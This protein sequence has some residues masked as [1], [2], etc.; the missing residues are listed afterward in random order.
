M[1]AMLAVSCGSLEPTASV[2][3]DVYFMPSE[4]P[5]AATASTDAGTEGTDVG[6]GQPKSQPEGYDYYDPATAE[7]YSQRNYYDMAYNDPYYYNYGRFGFG[8]SM[9][10]MS[11]WNGP[12]W[13]GGMGMGYGYPMGSGWSMS[14]GYGYGSG[15]YD[16]WYGGWGNPYWNRPYGYSPWG[17]NDPYMGGYGWGNY[18]GPYGNCYGCYVPVVIGGSS[19]V[20]VGHRPSV[21]SGNTGSGGGT[22]AQQRS[23]RDPVGLTPASRK[24]TTSD[25]RQMREYPVRSNDRPPVYYPEQRPQR[26]IQ[27]SR[28]SRT[29]RGT[30]RNSTIERGGGLDRGGSAP[31]RSGG[32]GGS[33][34]IQSPRPR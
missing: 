12:G 16:P 28:P 32:G 25:Q 7:T 20:V 29:N 18:Y 6:A 13:G 34:T 30:D 10:Y 26:P 27:E 21:T 17:W 8:G 5:P 19:G 23:F 33:R 31:S 11:G 15:F 24:N 2:R 3:D 14:V 9:G 22:V 4:A 1:L